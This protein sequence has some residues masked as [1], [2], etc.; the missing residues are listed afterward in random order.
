MFPLLWA[1]VLALLLPLANRFTPVSF[2][3]QS[4][5]FI[6]LAVVFLL[7]PL[8]LALTP[9]TVRDSNCR[10]RA[11][12]QFFMQKLHMTEKRTGV[13]LYVSV[14]EHYVELLADHGINAKVLPNEWDTITDAFI[15]DVRGGKVHEGFLRAVN[16]CAH[17]LSKHFPI[18]GVD[19]NELD[20]NL[21][22]LDEAPF[23]S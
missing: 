23:L 8:R 12:E 6:V 15:A 2:G 20:D 4:I 11:F 9:R 19:V 18:Q 17:V 14:D 21:V 10:R 22:E 13:L 5:A 1:A 16:S 7:T 3:C